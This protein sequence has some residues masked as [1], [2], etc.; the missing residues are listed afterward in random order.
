MII[1]TIKDN[2]EQLLR[3]DE[4]CRNI[5][6][7]LILKYWQTYDNLQVDLSIFDQLTNSESIRR[8]RQNIQNDDELFPPTDPVVRAYRER[9]RG[10]PYP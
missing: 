1:I 5:D 10:K 4:R 7:Y 2:V 8:S 9:M 3:D 6:L